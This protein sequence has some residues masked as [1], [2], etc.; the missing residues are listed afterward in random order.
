[1]SFVKPTNP[2]AAIASIKKSTD[3]QWLQGFR[4]RMV[5]EDVSEIVIAIDERL[6]ELGQVGLR[7]AIGGPIADLTLVERVREAVRVYE[8]FLAY[9]HGKRVPAGRTRQMIKKWGEIEAVRRTVRNLSM[10]NGLELLAQYGRLDCAYEQIIID[11]PT[12]FEPSLI[13]KAK[14]NLA[15]LPPELRTGRPQIGG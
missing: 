13:A 6:R 14:K 8:Q 11:H 5:A 7:E 4:L 2:A 12:E 15:G 3:K 10:S 9:K 1:M